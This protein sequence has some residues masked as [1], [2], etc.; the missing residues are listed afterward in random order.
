[1]QEDVVIKSDSRKK[2]RNSRIWMG[3]ATINRVRCAHNKKRSKDTAAW[4]IGRDVG[5]AGRKTGAGQE[6]GRTSS[7]WG[8]DKS[9]NNTQLKQQKQCSS[10]GQW[11]HLGSKETAE[12]L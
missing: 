2:V 9:A 3:P 11:A 6:M 7:A 4:E 10:C 5:W 12:E 8:S 1:M